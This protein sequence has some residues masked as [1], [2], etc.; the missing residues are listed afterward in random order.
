MQFEY[1]AGNPSVEIINGVIHARDPK[2]KPLTLE[3]YGDT[4]DVVLCRVPNCINLTEF[5]HFL[6][7]VPFI[8]GRRQSVGDT[9]DALPP[10]ADLGHSSGMVPFDSKSEQQKS[11]AEDQQTAHN[12]SPRA[13]LSSTVNFEMCEVVEKR[14]SMDM[15]ETPWIQHL[16]VLHGDKAQEYLMLMKVKKGN[17]VVEQLNGRRFNMIEEYACDA[18]FV[19]DGTAGSVKNDGKV[20]ESVVSPRMSPRGK[21]ELF[22]QISSDWRCPVC[23]EG[24]TDITELG[25]GAMLTILCGHTFHCRCLARWCDQTCAVCRFQQYPLQESSCEACNSDDYP[26]RICLVCG[27]IGCTDGENHASNHFTETS[28]AYALEPHSQRVWDYAGEGY[29]H[30]LLTNTDDGKMVE[31][32]PMPEIPEATSIVPMDPELRPAVEERLTQFLS[33]SAASS[34]GASPKKMDN[35][36]QEF[37]ALLASQLDEQKEYYHGILADVSRPPQLLELVT[38]LATLEDQMAN[39]T[40]CLER[41][42]K[43]IEDVKNKHREAL[44][45]VDE[46]QRQLIALEKVNKQLVAKAPA[47]SAPSEKVSVKERKREV[48]E[49]KQQISELRLVLEMREKF[50]GDAD[51]RDGHMIT[52]QNPS[53]KKK[54]RR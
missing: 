49:L 14:G 36:V 1:W 50:A 53:Q 51:T 39:A 3:T 31:H 44:S 41:S 23:M 48:A 54:K 16:R 27:F 8:L 29:V 11:A 18:Y 22:E 9:L 28:H 5:I 35:V 17:E 33:R 21:N 52:T 38:E 45:E 20:V 40:T 34:S 7:S 19:I 26:L 6:G 4:D 12:R 2:A 13:G 32:T 46:M 25:G 15:P 24:G 47:P 30:R 42:S 43:E 10:N 37:N